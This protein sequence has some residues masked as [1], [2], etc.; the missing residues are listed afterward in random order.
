[1]LYLERVQLAATDPARW[2]LTVSELG[3]TRWEYDQNLPQSSFVQHHL[4]QP[5]FPTPRYPAPAASP[6]EAASRGARF[7]ELL[8]DESGIFP[9]QYQGPMFMTVGYVAAHYFSKTPIPEPVRLE[10]TRYLAN[11]A[12]PVDGGWGLHNTDK[13]TCFGTTM[14]YVVLRLLGMEADHVVAVRARET[15]HR[16]GGAI[17]NPHW[18]KIWLA[19]LNLYS[20][21]GVNPCPP[22]MWMMPYALPLHPGRWW[23]HTRAIYLP[24]GYLAGTRAQCD[25]DP[26][27]EAIRSEIYTKPYALLDFAANRNTV[28]GVD[29]YYPHSAVLNMANRVMVA[30]ERYLRPQW[31]T[32]RAVAYSWELIQK[33]VENTDGITIAPVSHAMACIAAF[34]EEGASGPTFARLMARGDD[35]LFHGAK[36][37]CVMG[38]NGVQVWD[39][40]FAVQYLFMA[41]LAELPEHRG[42]VEKAYAF[43]ARSQFDTECEAGLFRDKRTGGWPFSTKTQG[44]T[45]SDCTA[46]A[47]KAIVMVQ[48]LAVFAHVHHLV[49]PERLETAVDILL[50]LQNTGSFHYGSF[51]TYEQIKAT[52]LLEALNPA[53]VFNNIMVE[54]PYV[55]CTDSAVLGLT[56]FRSHHQ[57]RRDDIDTAVDAAIAYIRSAQQAD[58]SWYGLWGVC[59]TYAGMFALE[60]FHTVGR[61][62]ANDESVRR[63]C[64][65]L[66][67][68]QNPDGG[69]S[70]SIKSSE[71]HT[72]I[73][74]P[75]SMVVQTAWALIGLM[76]AEYPHK[77]VVEHGIRLLMERQQPSGEWKFEA[78]EGVFNHSCAIEYPSYRFLFPIKALGLWAKQS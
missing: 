75:E 7:L 31:L 29:L 6:I 54:Y 48:N 34:V 39:C 41:G 72:Y 52:P 21:D 16:L 46:E 63:G 43:L 35:S 32:R 28:C 65:F 23:V 49:A 74:G 64:D 15:L 40:A 56:Y 20:W 58:G 44:Y 37:M 19:L 13:S 71:T 36:G 77:A 47:V 25:L 76:L 53:E 4:G 11:T 10:L 24:A 3:A 55:E 50:S 38:T 18:G 78:V 14:N 68:R 17:G 70:E 51:A 45:V 69:W 27:L 42:M 73:P 67:S 66:V 12:H 61:T 26:L 59:F 8:Q 60:A 30:W 62:Y 2:A 1:M 57:Y 5:D 9:C 33:E 22:E